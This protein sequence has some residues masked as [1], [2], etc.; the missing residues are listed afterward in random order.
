MSSCNCRDLPE[1]QTME[2]SNEDEPPL[3][4]N[5]KEMPEDVR[6]RCADSILLESYV[7]CRRNPV[8]TGKLAILA[9]YD[10]NNVSNGSNI[11]NWL[12]RNLFNF[13]K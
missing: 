12:V 10:G 7:F 6:S 9:M 11:G 3:K 13:K 4:S 2:T 8:G 5:C 1:N